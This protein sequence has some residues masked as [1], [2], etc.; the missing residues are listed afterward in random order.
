MGMNGMIASAFAPYLS[1]VRPL[2]PGGPK[3]PVAQG[4]TQPSTPQTGLPKPPAPKRP[5]RPGD[6]A[7][8]GDLKEQRRAHGE[9][10]T[11]DMDHQP[12]FAAQ[13]RAREAA[14]GRR[15]EPEELAQLKAS[16]PAVASPRQ[17]HQQTSPTFGGRNSPARIAEDAADLDAAR[18]RDRAAFDKAM[19]GPQ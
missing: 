19:E 9:T 14:L 7:T 11:L 10:E 12:S 8:Y 1:G 2:N 5:V 18:V 13:V 15:L 16:T 3:G 17:V 6:T 4:R